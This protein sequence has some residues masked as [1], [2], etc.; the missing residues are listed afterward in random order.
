MPRLIL[1]LSLA[2]MIGRPLAAT[3][4]SPSAYILGPLDQIEV[5]IANYPDLKTT[6][7]VAADGAVVLPLAGPVTVGGMST[8]QAADAIAARYVQGGF[9]KAP[10][11]R[12]EITDYQSRRASVLGEVNA[13]GIIV[14]DRTYSVAEILAK[15]GGLAP[16]AADTA[17]I[18]RQKAGGGSERINV[19]LRQLVAAGGADALTEIQSGDVVYVPKVPTF[20]V[21]GAVNK[22][23]TYPMASG[24]TVQQALA[25]AGD[26]ARIGSRSNL[27]I[28]RQKPGS[29]T[30]ELI[31]AHGDDLVQPGDV[32]VVRERVF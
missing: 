11:V 32:I 8:A 31:D 3:P 19:D 7:R 10:L 15:A 6:T 30:S 23:G 20:S 26:V 13:Q 24:L 16:G 17:V 21:I 28:R 29:S 12:V 5:N 25:L 27:K 4:P 2:L 22:A 14:L 1:A 9:I 18:V